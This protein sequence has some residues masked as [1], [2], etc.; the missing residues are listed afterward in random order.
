MLVGLLENLGALHCELAT[1]AT[2]DLDEEGLR[3]QIFIGV[4]NCHFI[5]HFFPSFHTLI[6]VYDNRYSS[7]FLYKIRHK[8]RLN[9][10]VEELEQ[11]KAF[12]IEKYITSGG[13]SKSILKKL[14]ACSSMK[15]LLKIRSKIGMFRW[16]NKN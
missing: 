2:L 3:S 9:N 1:A 16:N 12:T 15:E 14:A 8:N 4:I 10:D 11:F 5:C 13:K 7:I 6:I